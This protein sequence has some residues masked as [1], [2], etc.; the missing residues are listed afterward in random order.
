MDVPLTDL[1]DLIVAFLEGYLV[2]RSPLQANA[3]ALWIAHTHVLEAFDI[4]AYLHVQSPV[5][6][7]GK[8]RLL[9]LVEELVLRPWRVVEVTAATVFR[10]I[11]RDTP[12]LLLDEVDTIWRGAKS[13]ETAQ[14]PRGVLN[15]GYRRGVSVPRCVGRNFERL[16]DF[17]VFCPKGAGRHRDAAR[18]DRRPRRVPRLRTQEETRAD[19]TLPLPHCQAGSRRALPRARPL[20]SG[21]GRPAPG[22][23]PADPR[24]VG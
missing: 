9:E 15:A 18:H 10:K 8:T 3:L 4:T 21:R 14:A 16:V 7:S 17:P 5:K 11:A 22:R 2:F 12:T 19:G 13:S 24:G 1:L 23:P 20:G 6:R